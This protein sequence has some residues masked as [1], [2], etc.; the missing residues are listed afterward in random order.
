[1]FRCI[2]QSQQQHGKTVRTFCSR[3]FYSVTDVTFSIAP[4]AVEDDEEAQL[5]QLQAELAM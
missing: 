4:V 1:M 3:V 5:R 2:N